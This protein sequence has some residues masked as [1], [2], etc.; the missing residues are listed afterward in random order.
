MSVSAAQTAAFFHEI[1]A[2]KQVWT[3]R[4]DK[5]VPTSTNSGITSMPFWSR[6]SRARKVAGAVA[7]YRGFQPHP[8]SLE[9][10]TSRW[11]PGMEKDGVHVGINWSGKSATGFDLA[12]REVR[13]RIAYARSKLPA[14]LKPM[15]WRYL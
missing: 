12:P 9:E 7:A 10:F 11:L 6:E 2:N 3:L 4:D 14:F 15:L 1:V 8:L 13:K 5:G